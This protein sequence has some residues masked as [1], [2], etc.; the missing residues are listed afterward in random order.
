LSPRVHVDIG[1]RSVVFWRRAVPRR[2]GSIVGHGRRCPRRRSDWAHGRCIRACRRRRF[3]C[4]WGGTRTGGVLR[5]QRSS[6][7]EKSKL[8]NRGRRM[9][10]IKR[11]E[12]NLPRGNRPLLLGKRHANLLPLH[13][14]NRFRLRP[15]S[16]FS[17]GTCAGGRSLVQR[18]S[19]Y[20]FFV[21]D[22]W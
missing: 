20:N 2:G 21:R 8:E 18:G 4:V 17:A 12:R 3:L 9:Q 15:D 1:G 7:E 11:G 19:I 10:K 13:F 22:S 16:V 6:E 5:S 14:L